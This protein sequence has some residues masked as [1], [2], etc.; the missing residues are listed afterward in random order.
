MDSWI[1]NFSKTVGP[2][3]AYIFMA[4]YV[5]ELYSGIL[6]AIHAYLRLYVLSRYR[7]STYNGVYTPAYWY[8]FIGWGY[9]KID[10]DT[11]HLTFINEE[12]ALARINE[13]VKFRKLKKSIIYVSKT[14]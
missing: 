3:L 7:I 12:Q 11:S 9:L 2:S 1:V 8:V 5:S 4:I 10:G 14:S 13:D 6:L